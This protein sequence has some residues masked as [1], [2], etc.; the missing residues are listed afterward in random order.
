MK[1]TCALLAAGAVACGGLGSPIY[2]GKLNGQKEVTIIEQCSALAGSA[3][4]RAT[5]ASGWGWTFGVAGFGAAAAAAAIP[6]VGDGAEME[7]G[8]SKN[9]KIVAASLTA[10]TVAFLAIARAFFHRSDAASHLAAATTQ[11]ISD[12]PGDDDQMARSCN[13]ALAAWERSR[14]DATKIAE[15]ILDDQKAGAKERELAGQKEQIKLK[16]QLDLLRL[17]LQS[18]NVTPLVPAAPPAAPNP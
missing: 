18:V 13:G 16:E 10:S 6:L 7:G 8:L 2:K 1:L 4:V 17:Q 12:S 15:S 9:E 3:R 5:R 14:A 11:A